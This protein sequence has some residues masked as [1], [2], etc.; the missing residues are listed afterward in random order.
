MLREVGEELRVESESRPIASGQVE[1][2]RPARE[3]V[4]AADTHCGAGCTLGDVAA[5]WLV[6]VF[7]LTFAGDELQTRLTLD[8]LLDRVSIFY[9]CAHARLV[10]AGRV[11]AGDT[12]LTLSLF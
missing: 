9:D 6:F 2:S 11:A 5:E 3:Q 4:A 10:M 7:I 1:Q 8:F 12:L